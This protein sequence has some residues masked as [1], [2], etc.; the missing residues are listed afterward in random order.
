MR[1][2]G[3]AV[4]CGMLMLAAFGAGRAAA[5]QA[6][7]SRAPVLTLDEA[8]SLA[9][10]QNRP[11]QAQRLGV[12]RAAQQLVAFR[13]QKKPLFDVKAATGSLVAPLTFRFPTGAFGLFPS[14]GPVPPAEAAIT[15][16]PQLTAV[17]FASVTQPLTQLRRLSRGERAMA[18]AGDVAG[19]EV[20][21]REAE[22][23]A[24]V[25]ALYYGI[26][27]AE[28]GLRARAE[29]VRLYQELSRVVDR[30]AAEQA[31]LPAE[32]LTIR[33]GLLQQEVEVSAARNA[34]A[35]YRE[36]LNALLGRDIDERFEIE[37]LPPIAPAADD[38]QAAE[39]QAVQRRPEARMA[40]LRAE[41]AAFALE[42]TET[43]GLPDVS[44]TFNYTGFYGFEVLPRHGALFGVLATWEPWDWGR[45]RA[46]R[47]SRRLERE[48]AGIAAR[49]AEALVRVDVRARVRAAGETFARIAACEAAREASRER[50][51][52]ATERFRQEAALERDVLEAQTRLAQAD[53]DCQQALAAYWTARAEL[54]RARA[55][56]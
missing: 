29:S 31:V 15:T 37:P 6:P 24:N 49:E 50:L 4:G 36:Q 48:Q 20:R 42:A 40:R 14:I 55:D 28:A 22:V 45:R 53:F 30:Y 2:P 39:S 3:T 52:T 13:A 16:N 33:A 5:G 56:Q 32:V 34:S 10:R 7:A 41:Q 44:V 27:Q 8:V 35:G 25:K 23:A 38:I 54:E 18:L 11:L 43:P 19:E 17:V 46:Q 9:R 26:A 47:E 51:R 12:E 1:V 21:A